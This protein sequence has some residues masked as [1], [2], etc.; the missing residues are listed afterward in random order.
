MQFFWINGS[1]EI[2]NLE[3]VKNKLQ[4]YNKIPSPC[5]LLFKN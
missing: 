2:V 1:N 5:V 3:F 4:V